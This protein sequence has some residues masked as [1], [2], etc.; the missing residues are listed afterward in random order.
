MNSFVHFEL[1]FENNTKNKA[2]KKKDL[3]KIKSIKDQKNKIQKFCVNF[4][5][6]CFHVK[7]QKNQSCK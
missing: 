4:L 5:F 3:F 6:Q 1:I 2:K 7:L